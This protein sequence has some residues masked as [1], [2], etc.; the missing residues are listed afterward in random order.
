MSWWL[1]AILWCLR[2]I[3]GTPTQQHMVEGNRSPDW[4]RVRAAHLKREPDCQVCGT[5][6]NVEVHHI[7]PVEWDRMQELSLEN[8]ITLCR[9]HHWT[10]GHLC[11]WNSV[12]QYV[13]SDCETWRAKIRHRPRRQAS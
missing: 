2:A 11:D 10:F 13:V 9:N 12:N 8:V 6:R 5:R 7:V 4:P 1:R 3:Y